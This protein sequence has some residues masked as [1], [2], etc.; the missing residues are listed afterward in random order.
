MNWYCDVAHDHPIH[1]DYHDKEYGFPGKGEQALFELLAL[2]IFQ[3]GLSWELVLKKRAGTVEAFDQF[4]VDTVAAYGDKDIARLLDNPGIIRNK[5][6][7]NSIIHNANVLIG[8]RESDGGFVTWLDKHHPMV[9]DDWVKLF[10]KTFKFTGPEVVNEFL[11][12]T[13]YLPGAHSDTCPV[14]KSV[15]KANPPWLKAQK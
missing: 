10:R 7:V 13:G 11:M 3:A 8:L 15:L 12:S 9:K 5:L 4:D 6:K 2:E 1:K 14:Q